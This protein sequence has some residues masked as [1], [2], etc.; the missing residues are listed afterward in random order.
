MSVKPALAAHLQ[1][2]KDLGIMGVSKDA[3]W[4]QRTDAGQEASGS[5]QQSAI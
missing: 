2:Y 5:R 1:F 3:A 4:R